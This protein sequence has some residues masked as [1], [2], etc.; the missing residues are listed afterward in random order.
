MTRAGHGRSRGDPLAR[1]LRAVALALAVLGAALAPDRAARATEVADGEAFAGGAYRLGPGA[2]LRV[3]VFREPD[4]SGEFTVDPSGTISVPGLG[5]VRA[6]GMTSAQVRDAVA[7][8]LRER[9][10]IEPFVAVEVVEYG[11]VFV[12]GR[13]RSP[14]RFAYAP[15]MTV[16]QLVAVAGGYALPPELAD[17][18]ASARDQSA[19]RQEDGI[20]RERLAAL[21]VRRARLIAQRAGRLEIELPEGLAELVGPE[22]VRQVHA[23]EEELLRLNLE[24]PQRRIDLMKEQR[25]NIESEIGAL[26][27]Q[28]EA[29]DKLQGL[30]DQELDTARGLRERGILANSRIMELERLSVDTALKRDSATAALSRARQ[31]LTDLDLAVQEIEE[32]LRTE[33][34]EELIDVETDV[35][36]LNQRIAALRELLVLSDA[37]LPGRIAARPLSY[38]FELTRA[39]TERAIAASPTTMVRP[40]DVLMVEREAEVPLDAPPGSPLGLPD[41]GDGPR[42]SALERA[43]E[44]AR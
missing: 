44:D 25:A 34:L 4:M 2:E 24:E 29:G 23:A 37:P 42:L 3:T 12:M 11:P 28:A 1:A 20:S 40:G 30:I 31:T 13:V 5:E 41:P 8:A 32:T 10:I 35:A 43:M 38:T 14:G 7:A 33:T 36:V 17:G 26:G 9:D 15:G 21:I 6:E 27:A 39:G 22:R 16:L 19:W 18:A